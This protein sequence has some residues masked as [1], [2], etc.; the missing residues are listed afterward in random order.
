MPAQV[1][2]VWPDASGPMPTNV[3]GAKPLLLSDRSN[4]SWP[5]LYAFQLNETLTCDAL[6]HCCP[7]TTIE[8]AA[9]SALGVV[10]PRFRLRLA[11]NNR[12]PSP[13]PSRAISRRFF[14]T[15]PP[16]PHVAFGYS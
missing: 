16:S 2:A 3:P 15:P 12:T 10:A 8:S 13:V 5:S 1:N 6:M 7:A 9:A 11:L 14:M 4:H